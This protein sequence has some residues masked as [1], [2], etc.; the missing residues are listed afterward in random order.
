MK[1]KIRFI[2]MFKISL[3]KPSKYKRLLNLSIGRIILYLF[4]LSIIVG[5]IGG[6]TQTVIF[7]QGQKEL[8]N[9]LENEEYSFEI[10]DGILNFKNSPVKIDKD[11]YIFYIDTSKGLEDVESLRSILIHKNYSIA[12]LKDGISA[13]LNGEKINF[14]YKDGGLESLTNDELIELINFVN[15]FIYIGIFIYMIVIFV[16]IIIDAILLSFLGFI[17]SKAQRM[18]LSYDD[19][20]KLSIC[21]MT[22]PMIIIIGNISGY[23]GM[24]I[25][26]M[27]LFLAVNN[28]KKDIYRF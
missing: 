7:S 6:I 16:S 28:I 22:L 4:I 25:G 13:D 5:G 3:F 2:D 11:Q 17:L 26:G 20:F 27:Y 9:L 10:K 8:V 19:I 12:I 24:F 14:N 23:I 18:N 1:E 21:S 15:I